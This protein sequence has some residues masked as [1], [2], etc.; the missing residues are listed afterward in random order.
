MESYYNQ[1]IIFLKSR[2]DG[3]W[4]KNATLGFAAYMG[5]YLVFLF[6]YIELTTLLD[7]PEGLFCFGFI[8][9]FIYVIAISILTNQSRNISK[10]TAF[11]K[12]AGKL[13]AIQLFYTNKT[14]GTETDGQMINE[15]SESAAHAA[16]VQAHEKE[17]RAR[18]Q[19]PASFS[20]GL[21]DVLDHI[22]RKPG[23]Y[24][25]IPD[26]ERPAIDYVF[27]N[28]IQNSALS[29]INTKNARYGFLILNNPKVIEETEKYFVLSFTNEHDELCTVKFTNCFD[30]II[31]EI[32]NYY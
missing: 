3:L 9:S 30:G 11:I 20:I 5:I 13:Y 4:E 14:L 19:N 25:A 8:V 17:V 23:A 15:P 22:G 21:D 28:K 27:K 2:N 10:S 29:A 1:D 31:E 18:R 26:S 12:R 7:I 6:A 24:D 16:D 32:K